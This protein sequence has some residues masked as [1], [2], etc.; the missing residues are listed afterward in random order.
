VENHNC[1]SCGVQV[2]GVTRRTATKIMTGVGDLMRRTEEGRT[3]RVLDDRT[4]GR[5][6]DA[7]C[8]LYRAHEDK[9]H[10]FLD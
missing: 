6:D 4:I 9:K 5:S 2:A 7:V 10:E 1:L 3:G 8:D